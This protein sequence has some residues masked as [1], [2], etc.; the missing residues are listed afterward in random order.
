M[1]A[2]PPI[3]TNGH[4]ANN[5]Q[6]SLQAGEDGELIEAWRA[7]ALAPAQDKLFVFQDEA[8]RLYD[9]TAAGSLQRGAVGDALRNMAETHDLKLR[10]D[11]LQHLLSEAAQGRRSLAEPIASNG[12]VAEKTFQ[13]ARSKVQQPVIRSAATLRTRIFEPIRF[14]VPSYIAEGCTI[15]AGRP[16]LGKSW[17]MLDIGLAVAGGGTCLNETICDAGDVLFMGLEDNERRLQARMTRLMGIAGE[18]PARFHYATEWPRADTGGLDHIQRWI[19]S[20]EKARLVVVDV[21][22][23]FRS[24]R[25]DKQSHYEADYMAIQGLQKIA[26]EAGVAIVIVHHLRKTGTESDPFEKVSGTLGLSGAADSVLILDRDASGTTL[27]G[28]GRDIE[29]IERAVQ[30]VR[31]TCRWRVLG[32]ASEIR[33]TDE[34]VEILSLLIDADEPLNPRDIAIGASMPRNNVDQLLFKMAKA[35]EVLKAGRGRYVHPERTDLREDTTSSDKNDKK[36]RDDW[37]DQADG[38]V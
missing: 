4:P 30:F 18:W 29:E 25:G 3:S 13:P 17:L 33:R 26:S 28:R 19:V 7:L 23:M 2:Q 8:L 21:L 35:G 15:L 36:I 16:K 10:T 12:Y 37:G 24:P 31:E 1:N 27:Y 20:A 32:E 22:A 11:D 9:L 5:G 14:V 6:P 38:H 34:R